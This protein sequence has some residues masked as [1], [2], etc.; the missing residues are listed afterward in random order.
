MEVGDFV[1]VYET[2]ESFTEGQIT[3]IDSA[4]VTVDFLDWIECFAKQDIVESY[5]IYDMVL[6]A[7]KPG[8]IIT[9]FR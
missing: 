2:D 3:V 4:G 8:Q 7:T 6:V 1:R 9:D 5:P